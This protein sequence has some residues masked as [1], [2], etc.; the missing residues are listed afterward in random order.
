MLG[1][2][3][4]HCR[5]SPRCGVRLKPVA[6]GKGDYKSLHGGHK[7][8]PLQEVSAVTSWPQPH[9]GILGHSTGHA[10]KLSLSGGEEVG[11]C[12]HFSLPR[13]YCRRM[14]VSSPLSFLCAQGSESHRKPPG[15]GRVG[16]RKLSENYAEKWHTLR[17]AAGTPSLWPTYKQRHVT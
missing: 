5:Q 12:S 13:V 17:D 11:P 14:D 1:E 7:G 9:R 16:T 3:S 15:E 4:H 2:H 6:Y 10:S 8:L